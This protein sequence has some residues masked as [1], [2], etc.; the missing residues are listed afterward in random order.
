MESKFD[1][2]TQEIL[3][4]ARVKIIE[5]IYDCHSPQN[6]K[7]D[8]PPLKRLAAKGIYKENGK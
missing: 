6:K 8:C 1:L 7:F 3:A 2:T 4:T 5:N